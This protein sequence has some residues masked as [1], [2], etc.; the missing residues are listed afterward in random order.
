MDA[1]VPNAQTH[2]KPT[3][4]V[5]YYTPV[6]TTYNTPDNLILYNNYMQ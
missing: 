3:N 6:R 4:F 2:T 5:C 1:R